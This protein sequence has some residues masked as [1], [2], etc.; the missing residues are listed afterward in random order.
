MYFDDVTDFDEERKDADSADMTEDAVL[1]EASQAAPDTESA[2]PEEAPGTAAPDSPYFAVDENTVNETDT[3]DAQEADAAEGAVQQ[4]T[5]YFSVEEAGDTSEPA[6]AAFSDDLDS[7]PAFD[8]STMQEESET[9]ADDGETE[10]DV[11][12]SILSD[13]AAA[14]AGDVPELSSEGVIEV[15]AADS[16]TAELSTEDVAEDEAFTPKASADAVMGK[17]K[18]GV[19]TPWLESLIGRG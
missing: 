3:P 15:D 11:A 9:P 14:I 17:K 8:T 10:Q 4:D 16:D 1:Q 6:A 2:V 5:P 7:V 19:Q 13:T 12:A 18:K